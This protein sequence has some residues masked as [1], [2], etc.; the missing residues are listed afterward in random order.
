MDKEE[1]YSI[2]SDDEDYVP[3]SKLKTSPPKS[4]QSKTCQ[5]TNVNQNKKQHATEK[6]TYADLKEQ[7]KMCF[8]DGLIIPVMIL[9]RLFCD[10]HVTMFDHKRGPCKKGLYHG[11]KTLTNYFA[12]CDDSFKLLNYKN[13]YIMRKDK[14]AFEL[15]QKRIDAHVKTIKKGTA[16]SLIHLEIMIVN[17]FAART[18]VPLDDLE[19]IFY[20]VYK[21][22][23]SSFC[24]KYSL[25]K[26]LQTLNS[27]NLTVCITQKS[28]NI[29]CIPTFCGE[30]NHY[31][32]NTDDYTRVISIEEDILRPKIERIS[33][34]SSVDKING[35]PFK[36]NSNTLFGSNKFDKLLCMSDMNIPR[37]IQKKNKNIPRSSELYN[38]LKDDVGVDPSWSY[39]L[40]FLRLDDENTFMDINKK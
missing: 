37:L 25:M 24:T 28:N 22:N 32:K 26:T 39:I 16:I 12:C 31:K 38:E 7:I 33:Q 6:L 15:A 29:I 35:K 4:N 11:H 13:V 27:P 8:K 14:A 10:R 30:F 34:P 18:T 9:N 17:I 40:Q 1:S 19:K 23:L 2:S 3:R 36:S 20:D 21:M 5:K